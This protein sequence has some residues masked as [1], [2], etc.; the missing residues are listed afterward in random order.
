MD[1]KTMENAIIALFL[2]CG[3]LVTAI[4]FSAVEIMKGERVIARQR[5]IIESYQECREDSAKFDCVH[6]GWENNLQL[7]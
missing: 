7:K 2:F 5:L 6:C 1:N 4:A 3:V